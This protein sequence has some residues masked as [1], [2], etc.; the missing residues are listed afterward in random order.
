MYQQQLWAIAFMK[1]RAKTM[2]K[3]IL[4]IIYSRLLSLPQPKKN[5]STAHFPTNNIPATQSANNATLSD[6]EKAL[7][8]YL[9][10]HQVGERI[11]NYFTYAPHNLDVEKCIK[12]FFDCGYLGYAP[13][14]YALSRTTIANL[15]EIAN[16]HNVKVSGKKQDIIDTLLSAVNENDLISH[17]DVKYYA[18][19]ESPKN[20]TI[21]ISDKLYFNRYTS[22]FPY[23]G[24][25]P[26]N[27]TI[28]LGFIKARQ[29]DKLYQ[30]FQ[31]SGEPLPITHANYQSYFQFLDMD[32]S[33]LGRPQYT[34]D[35]IKCY[36]LFF[37]MRGMRIESAKTVIDHLLSIDMP[38]GLLHTMMRLPRSIDD[39]LS[40]QSM[41]KYYPYYKILTCDDKSVCDKCKNM[42]G[43]KLKI[44]NAQVGVNYPPFFDCECKSCRCHAVIDDD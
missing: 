39:I 8:R 6:S 15:K 34:T 36:A 21:D 25:N 16:C 18:V 38:F 20:K 28:P 9:D 5:I 44:A 13:I 30:F 12:K 2:L 23:I 35:E 43:K 41:Q 22:A 10:G 19:T 27:I 3:N 7:L 32:L 40:R 1:G 11:P 29:F 24:S 26:S 14:S 4:N 17:F 42:E 33:V 31:D 37:S